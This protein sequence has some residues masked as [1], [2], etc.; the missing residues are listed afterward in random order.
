MGFL[1]GAL[2]EWIINYLRRR[3]KIASQSYFDTN[4]DFVDVDTYEVPETRFQRRGNLCYKVYY[5]NTYQQT[6]VWQDAT[7]NRKSGPE[8]KLLKEYVVREEQ[9][10]CPPNG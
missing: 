5:L 9:V 10:E 3:R 8:I 1:I 6:T 4:G 2:V 7:G